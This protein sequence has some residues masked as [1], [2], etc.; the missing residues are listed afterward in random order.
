VTHSAE[1]LGGIEEHRARDDCRGRRGRR[2]GQ[3][4]ERDDDDK[5]GTHEGKRSAV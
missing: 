3:D 1:R 5:P 4:P 2:R